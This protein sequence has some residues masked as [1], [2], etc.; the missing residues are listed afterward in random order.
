MPKVDHQAILEVAE[1]KRVMTCARARGPLPFALAAWCYEFG[2]RA[3]EPGLQNLKD[4]DLQFNR[5][6]PAHL[7]G[8]ANQV[9]QPLLPFCREALPLWLEA[10]PQ[11]V[12]APEQS[13]LLFPS[14]YRTG[15]CAPCK[16][17][18]KRAP[19]CRE[20]ARRFAGVE[21]VTCHHC[22]GTGKAW[23][24][25]RQEVHTILSDILTS[26]KLPPGRRHPHILRHSIIT[27]MLDAGNPPTVV[28][29]RVGHRNLN[30]TLGYAR[31]TQAAL[32]DIENRMGAIYK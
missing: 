29:D 8:G 32:A 14:R 22:W 11:A 1:V 7:K 19:L 9:W 17:T 31:V 30:T 16:G 2:A 20:G 3:S 15:F 4:V 10:R 26:A 6:R 27:H 23:G 13:A 25:R 21:K 12:L 24:L 18:G 28:Q 5:A